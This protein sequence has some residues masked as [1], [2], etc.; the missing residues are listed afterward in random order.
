VVV[1]VVVVAVQVV[2]QYVASRY[3]TDLSWHSEGG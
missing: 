3:E 2:V 1:V